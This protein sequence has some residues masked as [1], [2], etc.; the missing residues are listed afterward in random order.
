MKGA[1][2]EMNIRNY[3]EVSAFL[4]SQ[5]GDDAKWPEGRETSDAEAYLSDK[6]QSDVLARQVDFFLAAVE[7]L[8]VQAAD[9]RTVMVGDYAMFP[10]E[11]VEQVF[12]RADFIAHQFSEDRH[13]AG[14]VIR[15]IGDLELL[16]SCLTAPTNATHFGTPE[17][18]DMPE[19]GG[20]IR[21]YAPLFPDSYGQSAYLAWMPEAS[22]SVGRTRYRFTL[23]EK[24]SVARMA[25]PEQ[26]IPFTDEHLAKAPYSKIYTFPIKLSHDRQ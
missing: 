6:I 12:S 11:A 16:N 26:R 21:G 9:V 18:V 3:R 20:S 1:A 15:I 4:D 25:F 22:N 17:P 2:L 10:T 24:V 7:K 14:L 5:E 8:V 13:P 23:G 19:N